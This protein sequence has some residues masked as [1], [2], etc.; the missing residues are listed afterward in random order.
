MEPPND[1]KALKRAIFV[2][3]IVLVWGL[4]IGCRLVWLQVI[5]H[6][7]YAAAARAQQRHRFPIPSLRGEVLDREG[8]PLAISIRTQ[9]AVV[10]PQRIVDP[11]FFSRLI[12]PVLGLE[13]KELASRLFEYKNR[14]TRRAAGR[15]YFVL[16]RHL[17]EDE[18]DRL[19][20]LRRTFPIEVIDDARR[21]YPGG[22]IGGARCRQHRR[23]RQRQRRTRAAAQ[24]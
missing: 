8:Y 10:N 2:G 6:D 12:A 24:R 5:K 14:G 15:G 9:S 18:K 1:E 3:R 16:K 13:P 23:G 17:A 21:E 22:I 11:I 7:E 20:P 4:I 19:T